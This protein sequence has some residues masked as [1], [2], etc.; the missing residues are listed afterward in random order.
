MR[1]AE[2]EVLSFDCFG[3][4]IDWEA[5]ILAAL[6]PLRAR[7]GT[8]IGPQAALAAFARHETVAEHVTLHGQS[9]PP[10]AQV[11]ARV[12]AALAE[13]WGV[14]AEPAADAAFAAAIADWPAFPDTAPALAALAPRCKLVILS[15]V[16]RAGFAVTAP[17]LGVA[18]DAV[19]TAEEIGSYK[20]DPRNFVALLGQVARWGVGRNGLVHVAQ[21][22]FHDH[23]PAN[24]AGIASI[25]IDRRA[26]AGGW[27]ATAPPPRGVRYDLRF[28]GL[29]ALAEWFA[30]GATP[31]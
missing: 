3:T 12:H 30:G 9:A 15:N 16:D 6:A 11:L 29:G 26:G 7:A 31:P 10:Y 25:W 20:P 24:A 2:I 23:A 21:S 1:P 14:P 19:L 17:K 18:F 27:G 8:A 28:T 5:G 4:L 13:E 22:L